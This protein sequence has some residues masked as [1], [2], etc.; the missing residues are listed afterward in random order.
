MQKDVGWL[1]VEVQVSTLLHLQES[2]GNLV[3][4]EQQFI[5]LP[6]SIHAGL[7]TAMGIEGHGNDVRV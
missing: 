5:Q 1:N 3:S 2:L 6:P 4:K 7:K